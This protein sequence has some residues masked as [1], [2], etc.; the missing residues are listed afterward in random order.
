MNFRP[1]FAMLAASTCLAT[2]AFAEQST[3]T[4][5]SLPQ[6]GVETDA[7]MRI[8]TS[9]KI[10]LRAQSISAAACHLQIGMDPAALTT[11]LEGQIA[12][13]E[14]FVSALTVGDPSLNITQPEERKKTHRAAQRVTDAWAPVKVA[15]ASIADGNGQAADTD[16]ILVD[17]LEILEHGHNFTAELVQQYAN[18]AEST[19]ADL[20]TIV[21]AT[22]QGMLSQKMSK[23]SCMVSYSGASTKKL[24]ETM[25]VFE[26]TLYALRDGMPAAGLEAA[27]TEEIA[28]G[29]NKALEQWSAV[30]PL[31]QEIESGADVTAAHHADKM[32]QLDGIKRQMLDVS[33]MYV[34]YMKKK[35]SS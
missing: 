25:S 13:F 11:P 27:P 12:E 7:E 20:F 2:A 18:P 32:R 15:A 26:N 4:L 8:R 14:K 31:L 33:T 10:K 1:M 5:V 24:G 17:N 34:D 6:Q 29:L 23:E 28:E 3:V 30:R 16:S 22:R 21:L 9:V 19:L 35:R